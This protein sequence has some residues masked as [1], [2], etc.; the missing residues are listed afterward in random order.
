M[1]EYVCVKL[2]MAT[3]HIIFKYMRQMTH[4]VMMFYWDEENLWKIEG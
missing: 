1:Y 3:G 4:L 2:Q